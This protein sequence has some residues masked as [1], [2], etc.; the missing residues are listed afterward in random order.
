MRLGS[1]TDVYVVGEKSS[2][3]AVI[4]LFDIFGF[5]PQTQQGADIIAESLGARVYMPDVFFGK[6]YP[7]ED[8]PATTDETKQK[9]GS[10]F[11]NEAGFDTVLPGILNLAKI[12]R[13]DGVK[14][15][16][17][18]GLCWGG[19]VSII[20]GTKTVNLDGSSTPIFDAVAALHPAFLN[21]ADGKEL[22]VPVAIYASRDESVEEFKKIIDEVGNKPWASKNAYRVYSNMHHGWGGARADLDNEEN[23]AAFTDVYGRLATF[24]KNAGED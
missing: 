4:A 8:F 23:K 15:L 10:F 9:L 19:K 6:P 17:M 5:Y 12:L 7:L 3:Q 14:K 20:A 18:Y 16:Y 13:D 2:S 21:A 24:Y 22:Q 11:Q 1:Y